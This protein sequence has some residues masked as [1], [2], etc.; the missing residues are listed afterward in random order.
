MVSYLS[1]IT[2]FGR[3]RL[4]NLYVSDEKVTIPLG[5]V[6]VIRHPGC[7]VEVLT[8]ADA[9]GGCLPGRELNVANSLVGSP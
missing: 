6:L 3:K 5:T 2:A 1:G 8:I 4:S 9:G 7:N